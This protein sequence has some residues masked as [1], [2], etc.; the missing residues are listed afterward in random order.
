MPGT[1]RLEAPATKKF[2]IA[3]IILRFKAQGKN[4]VISDEERKNL[5]LG[6]LIEIN[7]L[8]ALSEEEFEISI[9]FS[10]ACPQ[11]ILRAGSASFV[12]VQR[13]WVC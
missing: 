9:Q 8:V 6:Q 11:K 3:V 1:V 5:K 10:F 2:L 4:L 13:I 7:M 12:V